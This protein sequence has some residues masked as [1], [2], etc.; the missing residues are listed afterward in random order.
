[1]TDPRVLRE[2]AF[3]PK[4][5][6]YWLLSPSI[7]LAMTIVLIPI[8]PVYLLIASMVIDRLLAAMQCTLTERSLIIKK[9]VLNRVESTIPLE[10]ITDLQMY[11]GPVMRFLGLKGFRVETA[12]QSAGAGSYLVNVVG[13]LDADAFRNDV[14][15][16]V[17]RLTGHARH[18]LDPAQDLIAAVQ[19]IRD[20]VQRIEKTLGDS[21][22][23]G[24]D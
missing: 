10:K 24:P 2:G 3:N 22:A 12:G 7:A 16:E 9:G 18:G 19:E 21:P 5:K 4:V 8:I 11:Q 13:L 17:E 14:M 23:G 20:S 15:D 6:V 1:M